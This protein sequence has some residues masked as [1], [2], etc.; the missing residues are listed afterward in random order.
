MYWHKW[1][2]SSTC[3]NLIKSVSCRYVLTQMTTNLYPL[4]P[5]KKMFH[6]DMYWY[7]WQQ[8]STP[9][10]LTKGVL[11]RYVLTQMT[12]TLY[13]LQPH[14]KGVSCRYVLTQMTSNLYLLRPHK[15]V[16]YADMYWHERQ[17]TSTCSMV[18]LLCLNEKLAEAITLA[19]HP[20][21][22]F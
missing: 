22:K 9:F 3:F 19:K 16:F 13:L 17:Q 10:N 1:Q 20:F 2:Q 18:T 5:H 7:K 14:T 4:Q 15:K 11:C 21:D 8:T 12:T 6:A